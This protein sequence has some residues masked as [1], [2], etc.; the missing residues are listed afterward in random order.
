MIEVKM[1]CITSLAFIYQM[2]TNQRNSIKIA[3]RIA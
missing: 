1:L 3:P 2:G